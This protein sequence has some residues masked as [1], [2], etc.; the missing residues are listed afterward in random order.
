M[1]NSANNI[2]AMALGG[3]GLIWSPRIAFTDELRRGKLVEISLDQ[4]ST[5]HNIW[6]YSQATY[7]TNVQ[8]MVN[9]LKKHTTPKV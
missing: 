4:T 8:L 9:F 2:V 3:I 1:T 5:T 7:N 6:I